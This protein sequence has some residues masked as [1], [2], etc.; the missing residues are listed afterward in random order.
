MNRTVRVDARVDV[1]APPETVFAAATDWERQ[2]EWMLGTTVRVR[3]GDGRSV[4]SEV[5]AVTGIRGIGVTDSMR[6]TMWDAPSRCEMRHLGTVVRG[7]GIFAVQPRDRDAA[8]FEWAE[9]L[10][11][12][13][14]VLGAVGWPLIRPIFDW[15]L[16]LS[17][18]R[19]AD[20]CRT[21]PR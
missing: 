8:T 12:P 15:G 1:D 19:F 18:A 5:E 2:G 13:L 21:Y 11:L 4:G 7:T 6:I 9:Q 20:F 16:R 3:R 14:G 17:L 10:E